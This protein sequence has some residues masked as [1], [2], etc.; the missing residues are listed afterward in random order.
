MG[1]CYVVDDVV[2]CDGGVVVEYFCVICWGDDLVF[3]VFELVVL[4]WGGDCGVVVCVCYVWEL[5]GRGGG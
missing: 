3:V 1:V 4:G 5:G 2:D